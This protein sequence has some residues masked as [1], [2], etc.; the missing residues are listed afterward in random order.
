MSLHIRGANGATALVQNGSIEMLATK[1]DKMIG[2]AQYTYWHSSEKYIAFSTNKTQQG[3]HA[4]DEKRV[5]VIDLESDVF[6]YDIVNNEMVSCPQL[7]SKES[8]ETF[9]SFSADGKRSHG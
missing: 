4:R 8:F 6:V 7:S 2:N 3:F 9:P 5:E 1:T